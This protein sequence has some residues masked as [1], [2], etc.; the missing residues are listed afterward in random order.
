MVEWAMV[1]DLAIGEA[2]KKPRSPNSTLIVSVLKPW[3]VV[4]GCPFDLKLG[5]Y[6][7]SY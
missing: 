7:V 3:K 6:P 2:K 4:P 5:H 1:A